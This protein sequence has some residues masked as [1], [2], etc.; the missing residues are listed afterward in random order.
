MGEPE[1][2]TW[3]EV[4]TWDGRSRWL[5]EKGEEDENRLYLLAQ[6]DAP[7]SIRGGHT[8]GL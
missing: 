3:G 1:E 8:L 2:K 4:E 5:R 6:E 7:V